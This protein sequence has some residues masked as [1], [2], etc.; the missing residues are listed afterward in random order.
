MAENKTKPTDAA[1]EEFLLSVAP[2]RAEEAK[3]LI[4]V[5]EEISSLPPVMWGPSI[6][7]FGSTHYRYATGREGD[8]PTLGFSPRKTS[9]T[10]YFSEGFSMYEDELEKLG[11]H[12]TSVSCLYINKLEDIDRG[13]LKEMLQR[14]WCHWRE[15]KA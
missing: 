10:I 5:M 2:K 11:K 12:K 13:V 15:E 8:M 1:V 6:I 3:E 4:G 9:L 14:S 7:G